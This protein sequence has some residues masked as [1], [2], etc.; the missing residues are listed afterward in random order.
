VP[1]AADGHGWC[2]SCRSRFDGVGQPCARGQLFLNAAGPPFM[3]KTVMDLDQ[4]E[5]F[6]SSRCDGDLSSTNFRF[7][8]AEEDPRSDPVV[9]SICRGILT[10]IIP[11][12]Q[13]VS[14]R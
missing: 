8:H 13:F 10:R 2:C 14:I 6:G 1:A 11:I 3:T 12:L 7:R 5:V 4:D 9:G